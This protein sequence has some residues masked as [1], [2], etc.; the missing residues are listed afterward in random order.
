MQTQSMDN[1]DEEDLKIIAGLQQQ[2]GGDTEGLTDDDQGT[3]AGDQAAANTGGTSEGAA[4]GN[5]DG[6]ASNN[7]NDG[8]SDQGAQPNAG[9]AGAADTSGAAQAEGDDG[10]NLKAALRAAR[11]AERR[12]REQ[13]ERANA[14]LEQMRQKLPEGTRDANGDPDMEALEADFPGIAAVVKRQQQEIERLK[15]ATQAPASQAAQ[16]TEFTPPAL[17]P[18]VQEVVDEIPQLLA[19]QHNADQTGWQLAVKYE[20]SLRNDPD[21]DGRTD[22]ERFAEA[23]RRATAKLAATPAASQPSSSTPPVD[24]AA[25]ARAAAAAKAAQATRRTP[26]SLSDFGGGGT[27]ATTDN[28]SR[29]ARM[30]DDQVLDD[31][32]R[33]G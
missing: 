29:Y 6:A 1:F 26:E 19:L 5:Q 33:L 17:Q 3:D 24:T 2:F 32:A 18:A 4:D 12:Y 30:T 14:E 7:D 16:E 20:A 27:E 23:A 21:W 28:L 8:T 10:G 11:R 25:Q 9:D 13:L 31:L 15:G 22:A